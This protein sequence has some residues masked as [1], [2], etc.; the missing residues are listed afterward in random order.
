MS[1]RCTTHFCEYGQDVAIIYRHSDGGPTVHGYYLQEFLER[2]KALKDSRL[3]D[4]SYLAAR[5]LVD[6]VSSQPKPESGQII[7]F[8]GVGIVA[9]DPDD[10]DFRYVVNCGAATLDG[11]PYVSFTRM[12]DPRYTVPQQKRGLAT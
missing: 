7:D 4:P 3:D 11:L 6:L 9:Q 8:R 2:C 5:F 10:I 1:T 12:S